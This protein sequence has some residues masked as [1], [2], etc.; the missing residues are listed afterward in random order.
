[1][2]PRYI[3]IHSHLNFPEYDADR[4][5][6]IARM[7]EAG[8][9]TVTVGVD[10]ESS[11]SAVVLS[12][13]IFTETGFDVEAGS[14]ASSEVSPN[15]SPNA[16][17]NVSLAHIFA[18]IGLHPQDNLI[19]LGKPFA[20]EEYREFARNPR[21]VAIGECGL[22]YSRLNSKDVSKDERETII[23]RQ[24]EIFEI[25]IKLAREVDK[26]L[27][28]HIRPSKNSMD[29]Y[30]DAYEILKGKYDFVPEATLSN[31][32]VA[33]KKLFGNVHFFAGDWQTA[34]KFLAIGFTLS[35]T[36]VITFARDYDE[37]IMKAPLDMILSETDCPFVSPVPYRGKRNEPAHVVQVA[38]KIAEIRGAVT[39][40][41]REIV[42][43]ALVQNAIRLFKLS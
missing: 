13:K 1:M 33:S 16:P 19:E 7:K 27:M 14:D 23:K 28:L 11:R 5:E 43:Q 29:A 20:L 22:D 39:V 15:A 32:S 6:V 34:Q 40:A 30:E 31:N 35:F 21:V 37:T 42:R 18:A 9:W 8:V 38:D 2:M 36:G 25:Q 17:S 4:S 12:G 41:E 26:P 3:D 10:L 24:K